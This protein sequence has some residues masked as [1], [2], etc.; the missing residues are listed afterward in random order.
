VARPTRLLAVALIAASTLSY[1]ILLVRIFA[2]EYFHHFAYMAI[3]VAM[4]GFGAS[5]TLLALFGK[6]ER[7]AAEAGFAWSVVLT[8]VSLVASPTLVH[9]ISLDPTQLAWNSGQWFRLALVYCVLALPFAVGALGILLALILDSERPGKTYG[10]SFVGSGLGAL[11]ALAV[12]WFVSPARALAAPAL[13]AALGGLVMARGAGGAVN[14]RMAARLTFAASCFVCFVP[15]WKLEV[16]PYKALP[17][18]E[19]YPGAQR[20]AE[21]PSPVGWVVAVNAPTFRYA[22]GLSLAYSGSFPQQTALF[23]DGQI[24]GASIAAR[25][26]AGSGSVLDWLPTADFAWCAPSHRS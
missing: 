20:I 23:V 19:A 13:I 11:L 16:S 18:V 4:L 1:E 22:P 5:G 17:Q 15:L 8:S 9:Q 12:L 24:A 2:I 10:A 14:A 26:D 25:E 7:S 21:S 6:P 3:G